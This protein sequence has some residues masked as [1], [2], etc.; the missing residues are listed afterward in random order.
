M[1]KVFTYDGWIVIIVLVIKNRKFYNTVLYLKKVL[2]IE[3]QIYK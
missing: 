3:Y 2:K 1:K